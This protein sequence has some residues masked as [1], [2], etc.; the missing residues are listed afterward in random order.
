M[1]YSLVQV[2]R[3]TVEVDFNATY[4]HC[5]SHICICTRKKQTLLR[6]HFPGFWFMKGE[7]SSSI[8]YT[9]CVTYLNPYFLYSAQTVALFPKTRRC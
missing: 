8:Y 1:P 5:F 7:N 2:R 6:T 4:F 9:G 3:E